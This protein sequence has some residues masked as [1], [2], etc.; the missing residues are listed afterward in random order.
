MLI[1][2]RCRQRIWSKIKYSQNIS[3]R[4]EKIQRSITYFRNN[5]HNNDD[6]RMRENKWIRNLILLKY[7]N[8]IN[9]RL[10]NNTLASRRTL[11]K[12]HNNLDF[13]NQYEE[14]EKTRVLQRYH[15]D[16]SLRLK[17]IQ[18][19]SYSYRNNNTLMKR[20]LK[21]LYNQ[22]RRIL[23]KYSSIQSHMCTLKHRNLYLASVEK[24]RKII[25]EGPAY[26]CISCGIAL[27]RHQVLPFIEEKYLKQNMS[28]EMTTYIQSCLKNTFSSEQRWICKLCSDKIKKQRL[29]SR[30][31]MNKLEVC[32]IPSE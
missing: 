30:A 25:K 31:L 29:S 13:Q 20:N 5:C 1:V 14:R 28:L 11:N 27:F 22:R 8:N 24:F 15:S 17:M 32:E 19:A 9:Y 3:F 6:F 21:Q 18:N 16:H 26:V 7:H 10:E 23:K 12:Y 2:K 4:E